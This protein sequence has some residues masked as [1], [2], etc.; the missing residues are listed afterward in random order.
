[1]HLFHACEHQQFLHYPSKGTSLISN[2]QA[3]QVKYLYF[4]TFSFILLS[5][6]HLNNC[7]D[8]KQ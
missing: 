7:N 3:K 5:F 2:R 1:M 6:Q 8:Y 4:D